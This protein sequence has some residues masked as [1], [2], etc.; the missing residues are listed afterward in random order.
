MKIIFTAAGVKVE[1]YWPF[2][3]TK[4]IKE[5]SLEDLIGFSKTEPFL[6]NINIKIEENKRICENSEK[7]S[8]L[9][10]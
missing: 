2:L 3:F 10:T 4:L 7:K 1:N 8:N 6:P 9:E 5:F